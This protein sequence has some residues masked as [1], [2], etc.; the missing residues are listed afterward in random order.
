MGRHDARGKSAVELNLEQKRALA[1]AKARLRAKQ[2]GSVQHPEFDGSNVPGYNPQTG[3]VERQFN[4]GESAW[5]GAADTSTLSFGDEISSWGVAGI[6]N[7]RGND[8]PREKILREMRRNAQLAQQQNPW[9]HL[10]G[11]VGGALA[12][13]AATR[14]ASFGHNAASLLGRVIGGG[15]TG[16]AYGGAYG[17]GSGEDTTSRLTEGAIGAGIGAATGG[18]FPLAAEG[19]SRSYRGIVDALSSNRT[20]RQVGTSP[21]VLRM[22]GQA[23]DA[24]GTRGPV[25]QANMARAGQDAMLA[26]AGP[27]A[28]AILDT[29]I[30]RGGP[31]G[32]AAREAITARTTRSAG[33]LTDALDNTLGQPQGVTAARSAIRQGSAGARSGAYN[34]AYETPIDYASQQ[35]QALEQLIRGRVPG[36]VI[37]QA[38]RI[39][40]LEGESSRQIL[41]RVADDGSVA[42]ETLPDVRQ[43]DYITRALNQAAESGEG[44]GALGG[45]TTIGRAY[46]NLSRE[47]RDTLRDA[48]PEYGQALQTAADPI[49]RSKA[50]ELGSKLL[51]P[52][53]T[54]DQVDEAVSGM[55]GP[56]RQ[57]LAQ[58][59]R[60][61][62]DDMMANVT[63]TVQDGD[64]TAREAIKG[65]KEL[66]SRANREKLATA[67]GQQQ[68]DTLFAEI[69]RAATSFELRAAVAENSKTYARQ[70]TDRRIA[71][72][73]E[74]G[75]IGK[76]LQGQPIKA[77]QRIAQALTGQT[78]E[79]ITARQEGIYADLARIL[80]QPQ[81]RQVFD[82]V[83]S[84]GRTDQATQLMMERISQALTAGRLSYPA[85][86]LLQD[87]RR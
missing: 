14:G 6:E 36:S 62:L 1:L 21:D 67:I 48:V 31:G 81:S 42:F 86:T 47:I 73:T 58:G 41:A 23:M 60:S 33:A 38:N 8:V 55:T 26:D 76:A 75:A 22:L 25:G 34:T 28:R 77:T 63:R 32:V 44:A 30:Q 79:R 65:L 84:L 4:M 3:M 70:A 2:L 82:A 69:D 35:G 54:R 66:S 61:R 59:V 50:V 40:Q 16:A 11:Q 27:N 78:P 10:A 71:E 45:Q 53:M 80:T 7:L 15:L 49:R 39:M 13:G 46:Q 68:A 87:M 18:A 19:V 51:S 37:N 56:E 57:A 85:T 5:L 83:D 74:P 43:I 17:V 72:M 12:L 9:S 52:S 24:D 29:A 20:A 64:T